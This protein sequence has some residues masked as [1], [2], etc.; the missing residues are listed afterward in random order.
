[1]AGRGTEE[2]LGTTK[3]D[4]EGAGNVARSKL[5]GLN[6]AS[7]RPY[8]RESPPRLAQQRAM[9]K[10]ATGAFHSRHLPPLTTISACRPAGSTGNFRRLR[11]ASVLQARAGRGREPVRCRLACE[12]SDRL[13][14]DPVYT[15]RRGVL[16]MA[17]SGSFR[18]H[19]Q[20]LS[21]ETT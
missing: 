3:F 16:Q 4:V 11:S 13:W 19:Q 6:R 8:L 7:P 21:P 5:F 9:S 20:Y 17:G 12:A 18:S 2:A 1:M 10:G 14:D 15:A